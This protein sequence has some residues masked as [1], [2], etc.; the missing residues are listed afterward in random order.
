MKIPQNQ[1]EDIDGDERNGSQDVP[2]SL[3]PAPPLQEGIVKSFL[4]NRGTNETTEAAEKNSV[5]LKRPS[6]QRDKRTTGCLEKGGKEQSH[7]L[8]ENCKERDR[9]KCKQAFIYQGLV[10]EMGCCSFLGIEC[11]QRERG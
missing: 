9:T 7:Y 11:R 2:S 4:K 5:P 1:V 3:L 8:T 10:K 6:H